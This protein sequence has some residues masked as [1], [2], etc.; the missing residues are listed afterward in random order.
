MFN[1]YK[2]RK[3]FTQIENPIS[4]SLIHEKNLMIK[5]V[6][7]K[8]CL[9]ALIGTRGRTRIIMELSTLFQVTLYQWQKKK[10]GGQFLPFLW[11]PKSANSLF[12]L[13]AVAVENDNINQTWIFELLVT[14]NSVGSPF[15]AV[16]SMNKIQEDICLLT[17][18][19]LRLVRVDE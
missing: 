13:V 6:L 10:K 16:Y 3:L 5:I 7:D 9:I 14:W 18:I 19:S 8:T 12:R 17:K 1:N 2:I 15:K 11:L 4:Y